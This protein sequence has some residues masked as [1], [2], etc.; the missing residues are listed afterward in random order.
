M[1]RVELVLSTLDSR[2]P[3]WY[4]ISKSYSRPGVH[5]FSKNLGMTSKFYVPHGLHQASYILRPTNTGCHCTKFNCL[6]NLALT[7]SAPLI[8]KNEYEDIMDTNL[9][10]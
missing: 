1:V 9:G 3:K 6:G 4:N 7:I 10:E 8:L 2:I 5:K